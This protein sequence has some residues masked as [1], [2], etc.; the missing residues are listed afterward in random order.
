MRCPSGVSKCPENRQL[1]KRSMPRLFNRMSVR[2]VDDY[3]RRLLEQA[4]YISPH[5]HLTPR[6]AVLTPTF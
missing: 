5:D 1:M 4:G 6:V 2:P 3:S